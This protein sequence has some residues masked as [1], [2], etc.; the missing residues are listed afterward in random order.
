LIGNVPRVT[1]QILC[2][3]VLITGCGGVELQSR[4]KEVDVAIDGD[5][6]DWDGTLTSLEDGGAS[7]GIRNDHD[8]IY[9]ALATSDRMTQMQVLTSGFTVWF[10]PEGGK[11]EICGVRYPLGI[12]HLGFRPGDLGERPEPE[13]LARMHQNADRELEVLRDGSDGVLLG[14]FETPDIEVAVGYRRGV[15]LYE[16]KVPMSGSPFAVGTGTGATV[17]VGLETPEMDREAMRARMGGGRGGGMRPPGGGRPGG[18]GRGGPG[19]GRPSP[20]EPLNVWARVHLAEP[21][22]KEVGQL[23]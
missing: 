12:A 15:L 5:L 4:W 17:G 11:D 2:A 1:I 18:M 13:D 16:L 23:F 22:K 8:A 7:V 3:A 6:S 21:A 20:P 19:G 9:L 10:D 14:A